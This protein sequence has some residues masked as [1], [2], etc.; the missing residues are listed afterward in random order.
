MIQSPL[1]RSCH[2]LTAEA[3]GFERRTLLHSGEVTASFVV[4]LLREWLA[5]FAWTMCRRKLP[6]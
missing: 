1:S 2:W 3:P 6:G 5:E 4:M